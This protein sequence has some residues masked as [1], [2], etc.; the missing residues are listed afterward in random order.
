MTPIPDITG[1]ASA[2][3]KRLQAAADKVATAPLPAKLAEIRLAFANLK[4]EAGPAIERLTGDS[5]IDRDRCIYVLALDCEATAEEFYKA[6]GKAKSRGD[7]YL[8]QDNHQKSDIVYVGSSCATGKRKN[9]LRS[10]LHQHLIKAPRGTYALSLAE[11]TRDLRGGVIV[12][13]WQYPA[14]WT[15]ANAD[16]NARHVVL[17]M[18]DWLASKL[19]PMLGRR[20][21]RH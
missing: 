12:S 11:W 15:G 16:T 18:E 17:A 4:D 10:R 13:A 14:H 5:R 3:T 20:G 1:W 6:Y 21:S 2:A 19:A 8:P 7:L 9:T